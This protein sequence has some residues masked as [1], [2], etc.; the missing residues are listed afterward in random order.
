MNGINQQIIFTQNN[1][2]D[3]LHIILRT[4]SIII[5]DTTRIQPDLTMTNFS[6]F[7]SQIHYH[8][9]RINHI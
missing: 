3:K 7:R 2:E 5:K 1:T 4:Y 9:D 6:V 8:R